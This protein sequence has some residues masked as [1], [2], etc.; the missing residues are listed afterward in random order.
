MFSSSVAEIGFQ[1]T[2]WSIYKQ[3]NKILTAENRIAV[4]DKKLNMSICGLLKFYQHSFIM[5][6]Y[7]KKKKS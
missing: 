3:K 2:D 6:L 7:W 4:C 1:E 5:I